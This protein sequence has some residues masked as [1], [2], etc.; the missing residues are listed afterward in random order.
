M[1][2]EGAGNF[3]ERLRHLLEQKLAFDSD[4]ALLKNSER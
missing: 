2:M 4:F 3:S 1:S